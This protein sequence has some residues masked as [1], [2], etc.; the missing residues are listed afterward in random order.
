[1][2]YE[3]RYTIKKNYLKITRGHNSNG[4]IS[5][6]IPES[7]SLLFLLQDALCCCVAVSVQQHP[8]LLLHHRQQGAQAAG[9]STLKKLFQ[10]LWG[11]VIN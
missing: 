2:S 3:Y 7:F 1:M 10:Q 6:S 8:I 4:K 5:H 11:K 9:I